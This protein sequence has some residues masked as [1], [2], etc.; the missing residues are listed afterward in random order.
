[1]LS[2]SR[3]GSS[4]VTKNSFSLFRSPAAVTGARGNPTRRRPGVGPSRGAARDTTPFDPIPRYA[5]RVRAGRLAVVARGWPRTH[6][7]LGKP[8]KTRESRKRC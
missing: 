2:H 6:E 5:T 7:P 1:M 3:E 8:E 4:T